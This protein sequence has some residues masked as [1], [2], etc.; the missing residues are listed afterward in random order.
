MTADQMPPHEWAFSDDLIVK[1]YAERYARAYAEQQ[2]AELRA[3]VARLNK[4]LE[5]VKE[6]AAPMGWNRAI[7]SRPEQS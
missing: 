3:E 2:T 1:Q 7:S 6:R 4:E 5:A